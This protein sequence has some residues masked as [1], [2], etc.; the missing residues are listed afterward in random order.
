MRVSMKQAALKLCKTQKKRNVLERWLCRLWNRQADEY[1]NNGNNNNNNAVN[2][3]INIDHMSFETTKAGA[4]ITVNINN[5]NNNNNNNHHDYDL[6]WFEKTVQNVC[7]N[8]TLISAEF[9]LL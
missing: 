5:N 1:S 8:L 9:M 6:K 2:S 4:I 3:L 7:C